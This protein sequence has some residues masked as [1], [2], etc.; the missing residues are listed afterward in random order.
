MQCCLAM[1]IVDLHL[2]ICVACC[3]CTHAR[4]QTYVCLRAC[5]AL[6]HAFSSVIHISIHTYLQ[7]FV[8]IFKYAQQVSCL[9]TFKHLVLGFSQAVLLVSSTRKRR[10]SVS[11]RP[12]RMLIAFALLACLIRNTA[13]FSGTFSIFCTSLVMCLSIV[14][15]V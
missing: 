12:K 5:I 13:L 6:K 2:M 9:V 15:D 1:F 3:Q 8:P 11:S 10:S 14:R 4:I 7:I